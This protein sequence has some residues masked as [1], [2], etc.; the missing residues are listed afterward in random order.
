[1]RISPWILD[2]RFLSGVAGVWSGGVDELLVVPKFPI[3]HTS[4]V[5]APGSS[6]LLTFSHF[7][8][9]LRAVIGGC[10]E[11]PAD[12]PTAGLPRSQLG[13]HDACFR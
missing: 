12:L 5:V 6:A 10:E 1:M 3:S 8:F 7:R 13:C 4:N 9:L 2:S 11:F